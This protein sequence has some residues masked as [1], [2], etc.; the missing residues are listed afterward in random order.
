MAG[1]P[2]RIGTAGWSIP[3]ASAAA[4]GAE[5]SALERY[6]GH[7]AAAEIN[8]SFHRPH[9]PDTY[10]RWAEAAAENFLF[11]AKLPRAITHERRLADAAEPLDRFL[12]EVRALGPKLGPLLVQL[13]PKLGFDPV[14]ASSFLAMLRD[15]HPG[16]IACEPRHPDWFGDEAEALLR[17]FEIARVAADPARVP[18]AAEPG[19]FSGLVYYRLHGS[20]VIYR[21]AYDGAYLDRLSASLSRHA[22]SGAQAWCIFDNTMLGAATANALDCLARVRRASGE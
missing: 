13:P 20:P 11:S 6:A 1:G 4:F 8:S 9:R 15:R 22:A 7:F 14:I 19:G 2:I 12:S 18:Q 16:A 17:R 21:S 10:A 3:R 5:G